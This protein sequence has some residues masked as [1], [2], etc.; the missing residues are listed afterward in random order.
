LN[1]ISSGE[2]R[3]FNGL[4]HDLKPIDDLPL[5]DAFPLS[6]S[7][8]YASHHRLLSTSSGPL[9]RR[10][11]EVQSQIGIPLGCEACLFLFSS[12]FFERKGL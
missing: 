10:S 6:A 3:R 7:I 9:K 5:I 11:G 2:L 4:V 12:P 8:C 1:K